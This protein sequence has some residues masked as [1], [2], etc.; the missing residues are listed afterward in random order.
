MGSSFRTIV[1][2]P[3]FAFCSMSNW[4]QVQGFLQDFTF[5]FL[6]GGGGGVEGLGG[7]G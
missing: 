7:G 6:G 1:I 2:C 3:S 4:F 5:F